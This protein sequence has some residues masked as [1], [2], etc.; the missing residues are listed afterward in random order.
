MIMIIS[1]FHWIL[2]ALTPLYIL[3]GGPER[4]QDLLLALVVM[5]PIHWSFFNN[6]CIVSYFHK[7]AND[8]EYSLGD[9]HTIEDINAFN[10]VPSGI[11]STATILIGLYITMKLQYNVP[12]YFLINVLPRLFKN[13]TLVSYIVPLL[14]F[15][16]LRH[17]QY[18]VPLF[19]LATA[20][21][22]IVKYK[23]KNSCIVGTQVNDPEM[24]SK[25]V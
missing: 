9:R 23:D 19:I 16:F 15:Y 6:E 18:V 25:Q 4:Y 21:S 14:G 17:N 13:S 5:I 20:S 24:E 22:F 11:L 1:I 8:Q 10:N 12:L 7:K 3:L 2:L